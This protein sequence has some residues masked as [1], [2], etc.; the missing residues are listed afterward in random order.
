MQVNM[1]ESKNRLSELVQRAQRGEEVI[2]ANRG[3]PVVRLVALVD[4]RA[5][6]G[7]DVLRWLARN[8][9]PGPLR[10]SGAEID[11]GIALERAAHGLA[12]NVLAP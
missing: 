6:E 5:P 11:A 3:V 9:L 7:R 8:P 10:R 2:I 1:L 12:V 4:P